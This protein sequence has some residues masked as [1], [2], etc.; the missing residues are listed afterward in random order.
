MPALCNAFVI[1]PCDSTGSTF[2]MFNFLFS[3]IY[4]IFPFQHISQNSNV[5]C[6][7]GE[8]SSFVPKSGLSDGKIQFLQF[9]LGNVT[10]KN[11]IFFVVYNTFTEVIKGRFKVLLS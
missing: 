5:S 9:I 1:I 2:E 10:W 4:L 6:C 11:I 8:Y 7:S 3:V